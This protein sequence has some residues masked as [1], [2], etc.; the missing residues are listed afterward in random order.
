MSV[1]ERGGI[2]GV[3]GKVAFT[4]EEMVR[5]TQK[6]DPF[7]VQKKKRETIKLRLRGGAGNSKNND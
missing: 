7:A 1:A 5:R 4:R 3:G 6:E 2:A